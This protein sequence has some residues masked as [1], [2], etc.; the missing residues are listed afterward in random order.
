VAVRDE[1]GGRRYSIVVVSDSEY[2]AR[3][4]FD[5]D[6][7]FLSFREIWIILL[8]RLW[9]IV[10]V[11]LVLVG[12]AV[13]FSL[14]QSPVYEAS[15]EILV[16][17]RLQGD[18]VPSLGSDVEGLQQ[19]TVTLVH[20]LDSRPIAESV[21]KQSKA[22]MTPDVLLS[23]MEAQQVPDTQ[24]IKVTYKDSDPERA[25]LIANTIGEVFMQRISEV[26]PKAYDVTATVWEPAEVPKDPVSPDLKLN[27]FLALVLAAVLGPALAFLVEYV[28]F[29]SGGKGRNTEID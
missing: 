11:V 17:Q 24:F 1:S 20:S 15:I 16:G 28:N 18:A 27:V 14:T 26:S 25:Q 2:R 8:R 19:L 13:G 5:E 21:I 22:E 10:V 7:T 12:I 3:Q 4:H 29:G 6:E 9:L 23:N